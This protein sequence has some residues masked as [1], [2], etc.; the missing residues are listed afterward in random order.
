MNE[1]TMDHHS[2]SDTGRN[3]ASPSQVHSPP[4][5]NTRY[6]GRSAPTP[7]QGS[8]PGYINSSKLPISPAGSSTR[9]GSAESWS[10][11]KQV[12]YG[13]GK[14]ADVEL[15][16]QPSEDPE[17]PLVRLPYYL[18]FPNPPRR[19]TTYTCNAE[20][21]AKSQRSQSPLIARHGRP[22]RRHENRFP[23]NQRHH[24]RSIQ[25]II[26]RRHSPHRSAADSIRHKRACWLRCRESLGKTAGISSGYTRHAYRMHMECK[27]TIKLRFLYGSP[28]RPG[29]GLGRFRYTRPDFHSRYLLC[30]FQLSPQTNTLTRATSA[31]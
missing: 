12:K 8:M 9:K 4:W 22:C 24:S 14:Y 11:H 31:N 28:G 25:C 6:N 13:R 18:H 21:A 20:L 23:R 29:S 16:P 26:H 30:K 1:K 27:D 5:T 3:I 7:V 15:M 2:A 17:D 10:T 19:Q